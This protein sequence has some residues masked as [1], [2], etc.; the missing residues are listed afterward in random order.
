MPTVYLPPRLDVSFVQRGLG[1]L[2]WGLPDPSELW[3]AA[4]SEPPEHVG[5]LALVALAAWAA[6]ARAV[7]CRVRLHDSLRTPYLWRTGLL[8]ALA[9]G[10]PGGEQVEARPEFL[11]LCH[12]RSTAQA[13]RAMGKLAQVLHLTRADAV[14]AV[15][16]ALRELGVNAAE[17]GR[18]E[19]GAWVA[20]GYF[21]RRKEVHLAVADLGI[22]ISAHIRRKGLLAPED[23]DARAIEKAV[24]YRITGAG[25]PGV[26]EAPDNGGI[27]L[28]LARCYAQSCG[29]ELRIHSQQGLFVDQGRDQERLGEAGSRWPGTLVSLVLHPD[30]LN[31][32]RGLPFPAALS[33]AG[34]QLRRGPGPAEALRLCPPVDAQGFAADKTWC[35]EQRPALWEQLRGGGEVCLDFGGATYTLHSAVNALLGAPLREGGP[36]W[37]RRVWITNTRGPIESTLQIVVADAMLD[38]NRPPLP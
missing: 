36:A 30:R 10:A 7:G 23:D 24:Q 9:S 28:H 4:E 2:G 32:H 38:H 1:G 29:G 16:A 12:F 13:E 25:E 17:H 6:A 22:G 27:G 20:A 3:V 19:H 37:V 14:Q 34:V 35:I 11:P 18:S 15:N 21:P 8:G 33:N 31:Q 5:P 26:P